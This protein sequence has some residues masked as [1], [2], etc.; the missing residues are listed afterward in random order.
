MVASTDAKPHFKVSTG[1]KDLI[2]RDLITDEFVAI[3]ELVK[4]AFDAHAD[5]VQL[6]FDE[7]QI[8]IIDNGKGMSRDDILNKWLFV[9]YSAKK[10]GTEDDDYRDRIG[11]RKRPFAGAKGVGRFSCDRLGTHLTLSTRS[12]SSPVQVLDVDWTL[13]EHNPKEE[14]P[15]IEVDLGEASAF[16]PTPLPP[17][18]TT[19]TILQISDLRGAWVRPKLLELRRALGKLINPFSSADNGFKIEIIAPAE[20]AEDRAVQATCGAADDDGIAIS[21]VN[22]VIENSILDVLRARTTVVK[23]RLTDEGQRLETTLEDRGELIYRIRETNSYPGLVGTNF[24]SDIYYLNRGAKLVFAN[25]MGLPSIQFGSVFLFRN[26][27][28]IFPVGEDWN[29]F[30][31]LNRRKQQGQRRFLGGRDLIG[32]VDIDGAP[33]FDE[34][35][36]RDKGLIDTPE[37]E[38]LIACVRDK[39]VRRLERYVVD[40]TWKDKFDQ[41]VDDLSR[42]MID[43]SSSL[44]SQLVSRLAST[45][46]IELLEYNPELV[47]IVDEKSSEFEKSLK[48]L[49][50]LA[51]RTGDPQLVASVG[52]AQKRVKALQ[53][54]EAEARD[55]ER[56]AEERA[57]LAE[58]AASAA[59]NRLVE[60]IQRSQYLVHASSLDQDTVLNLHHQIIIHASDVQHGVQR[61]MG[62]LRSGTEI[63]ADNWSDFLERMSFRNSQILTAARF[64]TKGGYKQQAT[65]IKADIAVYIRDYIEN[66]ASLWVPRGVTLHVDIAPGLE[67]TMKFKPID[68]GIVIDNIVSNAAKLKATNVDFILRRVKG[69]KPGLEIT[70][71]DDGPGWPTTIRP[72]EGVF[73]KGVTTTSGSGLGLFHVKQ[74]VESLGGEIEALAEPYSDELDG[75]ALLIRL[76][77]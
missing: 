72:L 4:N 49:E 45:E 15:D 63:S 51:D 74:V 3:F 25:R 32:R 23:L 46:G 52:E 55:A 50:L 44:I 27:F 61:M 12:K 10:D 75:A 35:T 43:E 16:P 36:S 69:D 64:A 58:R 5:H 8:L 41:H 29:D 57:S 47:R 14:F 68:I 42:M 39:A 73:A 62:L 28:R 31:G 53:L 56:R 22:G 59:E 26:G 18:R 21:T 60:E 37:V 66:V 9:A 13:Y 70:V 48:A 38:Q 54:A 17:P 77:A 20:V 7:N 6:Y 2:G 11:D 40:I 33:G 1:L 67:F 24:S 65:D 19:G 30:F 34:S 76:P 71:A